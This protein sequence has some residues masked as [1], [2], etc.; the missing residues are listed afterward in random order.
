[1]VPVSLGEGVP[2]SLHEFLTGPVRH[3][4]AVGALALGPCSRRR[5]VPAAGPQRSARAC[6]DG[7]A[8][9]WLRQRLMWMPRFVEVVDRLDRHRG[10]AG[11]PVQGTDDQ[12]SPGLR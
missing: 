12:V 6:L 7:A 1:M 9:V 10:G 11:E 2:S 5:L 3:G 8:D 4:V